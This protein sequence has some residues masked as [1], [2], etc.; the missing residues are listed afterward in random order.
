[1]TTTLICGAVFLVSATAAML[2]LAAL[3]KVAQKSGVRWRISL[4]VG[5]VSARRLRGGRRP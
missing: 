3:V 1:M 5:D 4:G 2:A